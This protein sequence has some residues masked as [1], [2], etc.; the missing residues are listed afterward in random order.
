MIFVVNPGSGGGGTPGGSN[1]QVQFNDSGAFGG[2]AGLT[3]NKTT[4]R[5]SVSEVNSLTGEYLTLRSIGDDGFG[6]TAGIQI[7][8]QNAL[9]DTFGGEIILQ[10]GNGLTTGEGGSFTM[11][12]G[13]GGEFGSGGGITAYAGNAGST[14]GDGG[15]FSFTSGN[16][17]GDG[18]SAGNVT[19][20]TG[21]GVSG[22]TNGKF[23]IIGNSSSGTNYA[24]LGT[25]NLTATRD[26]TFP[27]Q[28]GVLAL[29]SN[30]VPGGSN[31]QI[32]FN[33]SSVF[34]GDSGLTF[35]K[36]TNLLTVTGT[37]SAGAGIARFN[38]SSGTSYVQVND[39]GTLEINA[40]VST[41]AVPLLVKYNGSTI[42]QVTSQGSI[43][44]NNFNTNGDTGAYAFTGGTTFHGISG[45]LGVDLRFATT[46]QAFRV[47][48]T[49]TSSTSYERGV[50]Q[51]D[52]NVLEIGTEKG[53]GGGTA[54]GLAL[55]TDATTRLSISST[56]LITVADAL[57]IA[58]GSTTGTKI[59][60]ATTQKIGFWNATP[61]VQPTTAVSAATFVANTSLIANDTATFD[62]YTIGQIVKALR[63]AGLLA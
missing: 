26:F 11:Q 55:Q 25:G 6:T 20:A 51:W 24:T 23:R 44:S 61:I 7:L 50:L 48:N 17:R 60:T 5:L 2:D 32:Q 52:T 21:I 35:N 34:G 45:S 14:E 8:A 39:N 41:G 54:R 56:G 30:I 29:T 47:Y 42:A 36:T 49:Y 38:P 28:S 46:A 16:G 9:D 59:A 31:T 63:N 12:A 19:F 4:N 3:Y 18:F 40:D 58:V 10:A 13:T 33:D 22:A 15:S 43:L 53:S 1:T 57:D 37:S 62:G 27:N